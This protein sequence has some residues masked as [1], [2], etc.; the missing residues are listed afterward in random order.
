[1]AKLSTVTAPCFARRYRPERMGNC[2]ERANNLLAFIENTCKNRSQGFYGTVT[3]SG[4]GR[5]G[6]G[7]VSIS[8][9]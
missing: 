2:V 1:M 7:G 5:N 3:K 4:L 8:R 6:S 9:M